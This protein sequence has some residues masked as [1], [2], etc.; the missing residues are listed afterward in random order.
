[1]LNTLLVT[2]NDRPAHKWQTTTPVIKEIL[3]F[4]S[5]ALVTVT[6]NP[7]DLATISTAKYDFV[8]LNYCNWKDS[9][10]LSEEAKNGFIN[11][12]EEGGGLMVLHFSNGAF[13]YSLPEAGES[14]WPEYR[15]IV[16]QVWNQDKGSTHDP[17]GKFMVEMSGWDHYI[18]RG[19]NDFETEDELYYNQIGEEELPALY[20][21]VSKETGNPEPLAW[22]YTYKNARVFQ[23][24]LGHGP[25]SYKPE[26]YREILRRAA[27]WVSGSG[28]R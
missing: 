10:G 18:T 19:L 12:L 20:S 3:E 9:S 21:A 5:T 2:G 22:A 4:D 15:K 23:S 8:I 24:L 17:Y 16:H 27:V 7:E 25:E 26:T 13:H 14:D 6:E 28:K 11:Y 1:M